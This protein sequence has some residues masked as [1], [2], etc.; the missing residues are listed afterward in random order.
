MLIY[1]HGAHGLDDVLS[2][3]P[4]EADEA[5]AR[6][7]FARITSPG[8]FMGIRLSPDR[9]FQFYLNPDGTVH[10]EVLNEERQETRSTSV[11]IPLAELL[12]EAAYSGE[13]F[14]HK[15][16]FAR[17]SWHDE[18]LKQSNQSVQTTALSRR[19]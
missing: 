7:V 5:E 17:L 16:G 4:A 6:N 12:I 1:H 11:N 13:D 9:I 2:S 8:G 15:I 10:A 18:K 14:E 19:V 3:S